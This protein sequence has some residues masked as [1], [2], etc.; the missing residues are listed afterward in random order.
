MTSV[1]TKLQAESV[2]I[3]SSR[4][5]A[6]LALTF[7]C[8]SVT[9]CTVLADSYQ[10]PTLKVVRSFRREDGA[11]LAHL[12]NV[13]GGI[14]G[15]DRLSTSIRVGERAKVQLTTT[16]ATRIYRHRDNA[17][18]AYQRNEI[19]VGENGLL[20]YV[21]D[22][23]IPFAGSAYSQRTRINLEDGAGLFWWEIVAP[24]REARGEI[25]Q[26][27]SLEMRTDVLA[28]GQMI[29]S[30]RVR[31]EPDIRTVPD[32]ARL[33]PFRY[34]SSFYICKIGVD[35]KVWI[36]AE[37]HLREVIASFAADC[38][39][40]IG[41]STLASSGLAIRCLSRHGRYLLPT[42]YATWDAAKRLLYGERAVP[43]RKVN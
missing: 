1:A 12:H 35:S 32:L 5:D 14:L 33:G 24:G 31:L 11:A 18:S 2:G 30:D 40:L 41:I 9:G 16:G 6:E 17:E 38:N 39:L 34:W 23:I 20:E 22:A 27:R 3:R 19:L 28:M 29:A 4:V 26:Y 13:S 8:E 15:G 7:S 36:D 43:P 21:P 42:L 37:C 25:F 10:V